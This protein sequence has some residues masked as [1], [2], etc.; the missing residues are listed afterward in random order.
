M[1]Q[2]YIK[3][4]GARVHNLKNLSVS[5]PKNKL[6]AISG[7][8]GSGK[9][10]LAFDTL[11]AEGQRRYVESLSSYARQFLGVMEKPDVDQIEGL[12]PAIAIDQRSLS[13]NPRSTVGTITE[14]YDYM[15]LLWAR[16]GVPYCPNCKIRINAQSASQIIQQ[17]LNEFLGKSI[18]ILA[19]RIR[20]RRGEFQEIFE[21]A[22][23]LGF[24]RVR[25]DGVIKHL[26]ED[27]YLKR[28]KQHWIEI[29]VDR[30]IIRKDEETKN[31]VTEAIEKALHLGKGRVIVLNLD[32]K[33]EKLFSELFSCPKCNFSF[34]EI[35]PRLFSFN[36]PYGACPNCE[37]L[38]FKKI[39]DPKLILPNPR[40]TISE[41]AI[42]PWARGMARSTWYSLIL[43]EVADKH[44]FSLDTPV[45]KLSKR[46]KEIILYGT[47][48]EIFFVRGY[49]TGYEGVIPHLERRYRE[50]NSDFI[51]REIEQY[52][53]EEICETCRGS[54]LK[55]EVLAI[56][57]G[58]QS[59]ASVAALSLDKAKKFFENL[60]LSSAEREISQQIL[61][62]IIERLNFLLEVGV[63]YLTLDRAGLT[64]SSGEGQRIRL[65]TQIGSSLSGVLYILDEPTIGL[66][67]KDVGRLIKSLERLKNLDNTVIVVEH[68][69][70]TLESADWILDIGPGA[71]EH[72]GKL[73]AEG[74]P[75]EIKNNEESLTGA[76]LSGRKNILVPQERRKGNGKHL[77]ILGA[78]EHNLQ[79]INVK[80]PLGKFVSIA[81]VSGSGKSTLIDDV[82]AK[83]MIVHFHRAKI[84]VGTHRAIK[85]LNHIDKVVRVDQSPIGRTPRSNPVTYT[86]IFSHMRS[87]FA[88]TKE[89]QLRGYRPSR[90]SFNVRGG[91]CEKCRGE[92][93]IKIEMFFLPDVY[94]TCPE[95]EGTRYNPETLEINF[96]GKNIAEILDM[97]VS[98]ALKFFFV[99]RPVRE[100]LSIL[101]KIG[102]GY[103]K[104]GQ[105]ATTLS[106]GE[107]Q[108]IKLAL[109]LSKKSTGKTLYVLDEPTVGLHF[110][111]VKKLLK[112]LNALVDRGN[113]VLVIEHNLEVLKT[114]DWIID[115]GP[116]GG[117][118]GGKIVAQG[119]PEKIAK[120]KN[121]ATGKY[122]KEI[123]KI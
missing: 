50:T 37:G 119:T 91:R 27:F 66:H 35:E 2:K 87:L 122:L 65:A 96:R 70:E 86:G 67:Q 43:E 55:K 100:K 115:M 116:E 121:S 107:A 10:S 75:L 15:R 6:V 51:R 88:Q 54:R 14:I 53:V 108:R 82:L 28:Y 93:L 118:K 45:G 85:G 26:D 111:D 44:R 79:N 76:Y 24:I 63:D 62:E 19:P 58:S 60:E 73:V 90:F 21:E 56:R 105:P 92:G 18:A 102:L 41:G 1:P 39:I 16:V 77:E 59:I 114:A 5:I 74:K 25:V 113:T 31:R 7:L 99:F 32:N 20:G 9:S 68:D 36:S 52:M 22:R 84:K 33:K 103:L 104:L 30:L 69:K 72:G 13:S 64:L 101:E 117:E 42:R 95:C 3:V 48:D 81:G 38:G 106:G 78:K 12:S 123:L 40:L 11:Y 61:K 29:V 23:R 4:K 89:S 47:S 49:E 46:A 110:E 97:T 98:E 57:I 34:E 120:D 71:G 83:A 17:I 112:V 109:E 94:I 80:I 8:S